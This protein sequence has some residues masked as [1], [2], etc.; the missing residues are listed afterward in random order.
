MNVDVYKYSVKSFTRIVR[1]RAFTENELVR[2][3]GIEKL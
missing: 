1:I 3:E 2:E